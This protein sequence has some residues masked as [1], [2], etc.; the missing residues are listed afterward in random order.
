MDSAP[1]INRATTE[2]HASSKHVLEYGTNSICKPKMTFNQIPAADYRSISLVDSVQNHNLGGF[3]P[4]YILHTRVFGTYL[5]GG[6]V[7]YLAEKIIR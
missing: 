5:L 4:F 1:P 7:I 3:T 6:G 2:A